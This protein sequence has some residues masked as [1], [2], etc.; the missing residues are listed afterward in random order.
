MPLGK[1]VG[2]GPGH[3]M[4]DWDPAPPPKRG[5]PNF[6]LMSVVAKQSPIPVTA[7]HTHTQQPFY[8]PLSGTTQVSRYQKKHTF[9]HHPDHHPISISF[10]H[11]T[12]SIFHVQITCLAIFLH[13]LCPRPVWST[14]WS[15]ALH[16]I[17][18]TFLHPI[19]VFFLQHMP[20]PLQPV[21][22]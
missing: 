16:L 9:T 15:G 22:L 2:L 4:L 8:G 20:M 5:T 10:F 12:R 1:V 19:I 13:K 18:H 17:F 11:L 21:L 7:E 14:S 3:I 6:Q